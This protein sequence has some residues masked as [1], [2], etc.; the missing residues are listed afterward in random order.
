MRA[1]RCRAF[2]FL[3]VLVCLIG[4]VGCDREPAAWSRAK[5]KNTIEAYESYLK[6][7]AAGPHAV[8]AKQLLAERQEDRAWDKAQS[9]GTT[10]AV[11]KY[12]AAY[13]QGR[14]ATDAKKCR[15]GLVETQVWTQ[16]KAANTIDSVE[17]FLRQY[18]QTQRKAEAEQ[19]LVPLCETRDWKKATKDNS[20]EAFEAFLGRY[21]ASDHAAE[22]KKLLLPLQDR[23]AW[24]GAVTA[25]TAESYQ[26]YLTRY[27]DGASARSAKFFVDLAERGGALKDLYEVKGRVVSLKGDEIQIQTTEAARVGGLMMPPSVQMTFRPISSLVQVPGQVKEGASVVVYHKATRS[28]GYTSPEP[29]GILV[30][31]GG[32]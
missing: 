14:F 9:T 17:S 18:P 13:P 2:V 32:R 10:E 19:I 5:D 15:N 8:E 29:V 3:G 22:A 1:Y 20:A 28:F 6:E 4:L 26:Q 31:D 7:H 21:P 16:A 11:D 27:P 25:H 23:Q 12:L 30:T 24:N